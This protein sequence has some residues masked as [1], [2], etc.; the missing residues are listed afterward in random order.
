MLGSTRLLHC[1]FPSFCYDSK[2]WSASKESLLISGTFLLL[3]VT[4]AAVY[5]DA[6]FTQSHYLIQW[7]CCPG[8]MSLTLLTPETTFPFCAGCW[9]SM[10]LSWSFM[11][12]VS[13]PVE[14]QEVLH[15]IFLAPLL[16]VT[17]HFARGL[18]T[19]IVLAEQG[20][21]IT[22]PRTLQHSKFE[23]LNEYIYLHSALIVIWLLILFLWRGFA[24]SYFSAM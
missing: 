8:S 11:P 5:S 6:R 4:A 7:F 10:I 15:S 20:E 13:S 17:T 14:Q 3:I 16:C 22:Q 2:C 24:H 18:F 21:E 19:E 1:F 9:P 12:H 23:A